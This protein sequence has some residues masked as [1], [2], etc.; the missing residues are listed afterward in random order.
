MLLLLENIFIAEHTFHG[1]IPT[2]RCGFLLNECLANYAIF[3]LYA[4]FTR[5]AP[6]PWIS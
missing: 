6:S 3:S 2:G 1:E 5:S 4:T